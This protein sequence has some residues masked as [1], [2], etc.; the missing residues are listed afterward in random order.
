MIKRINVRLAGSI[1][2]LIMCFLAIMNIMILFHVV[3]YDII[4]GGQ[5]KNMAVANIAV[6]LSLIIIILFSL[7]I[8]LKL[9]YITTTRFHKALTIGI[10]V[11]FIYF[12]LNTI[13][14]LASEVKFENFVFAPISIV[15][16]F[17]TWRLAVEK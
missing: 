9:N 10:W 2:L 5:L 7:M 17:L 15:V 13:G 8:A 6:S 1:L 14:N 11:M 4:M 12:V 16:S 3:P